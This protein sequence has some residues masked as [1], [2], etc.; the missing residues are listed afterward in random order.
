[1]DENFPTDIRASAQSLFNLL[2][3]GV[4]P[5]FGNF[6]WGRL[7]EVFSTVSPGGEK[8]IDFGRLFLVPLGL[9]LLATTILA[10]FFHPKE[11]EPSV[12]PIE[13]ELAS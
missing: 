4:G 7:G 9:A 6:L 1:V 12:I 3:L 2:I 8:Q 10:L 5:F 11:R 13:P